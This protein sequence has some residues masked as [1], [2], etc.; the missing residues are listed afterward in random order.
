M[1]P[2]GE[3]CFCS[4][5]AIWPPWGHVQSSYGLQ[6]DGV[7]GQWGSGQ[8]TGIKL[9][10]VHIG[11]KLTYW[12]VPRVGNLTQPP[13][14]KVEDQGMSEEVHHFRKYPVIIWMSFPHFDAFIS[15]WRMAEWKLEVSCCFL[16]FWSFM[17][18][19]ILFLGI[20][21][22][23][24][25][26]VSFE[27]MLSTYCVPWKFCGSFIL[28]IGYFLWFAGTNFCGLRWLKFLVGTNFCNSLFKQQ[29]I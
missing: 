29:N 15:L 14:W 28:R 16:S 3:K 13:S 26:K 12:N 27:S 1:N 19:S 25:H 17:T 10:E 6:Q 20:E 23:Y 18:K 9:T 4:W 22:Q 8:P 2:R 11:R 7:G 21:K 5:P 24:L